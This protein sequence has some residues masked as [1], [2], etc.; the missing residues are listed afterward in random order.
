M[1]WKKRSLTGSSIKK[2]SQFRIKFFEPEPGSGLFAEILGQWR[3]LSISMFSLN[4]WVQE[5]TIH[6]NKDLDALDG[7]KISILIFVFMRLD[8]SFDYILYP[9]F[10]FLIRLYFVPCTLVQNEIILFRNYFHKNIVITHI[11]RLIACKSTS[12]LLSE[13]LYITS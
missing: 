6:L 1:I 7:G 12:F 2:L 5:K 11:N 13:C 9:A 10:R 3:L 8:S 4:W